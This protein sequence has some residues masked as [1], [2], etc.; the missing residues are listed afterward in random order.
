MAVVER[1]CALCGAPAGPD[2]SAAGGYTSRRPDGVVFDYCAGCARNLGLHK[3]CLNCR[4]RE[5]LCGC[6]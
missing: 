4:Q 6:R 1:F 3:L 2:P 5:F